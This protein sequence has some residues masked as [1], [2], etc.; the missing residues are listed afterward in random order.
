[1]M[2]T[3]D[4]TKH[5]RV[6]VMSLDGEPILDCSVKFKDQCMLTNFIKVALQNMGNCHV[7]LHQSGELIDNFVMNY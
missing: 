3:L 7:F 4:F 6:E 2:K 1:M 5:I